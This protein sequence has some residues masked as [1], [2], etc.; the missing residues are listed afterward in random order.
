MA[1]FHSLSDVQDAVATLRE[2][3]KKELEKYCEPLRKCLWEAKCDVE[4]AYR[5]NM[6]AQK[7][8]KN[9]CDFVDRKVVYVHSCDDILERVEQGLVPAGNWN[10]NSIRPFVRDPAAEVRTMV[11]DDACDVRSTVRETSSEIRELIRAEPG[12][13]QGDEEG[14]DV[15]VP[16]EERRHDADLIRTRLREAADKYRSRSVACATKFR[17]D[18]RNVADQARALY[19]NGGAL[20]P[21]PPMQP[22]AAA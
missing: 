21:P 7:K 22:G 16:R 20:A 17:S 2:N 3:L 12:P 4:E 8:L 10:G 9:L 13:P 15:P 5:T 11:H 6:E 19:R 14:D 18:L 1:A